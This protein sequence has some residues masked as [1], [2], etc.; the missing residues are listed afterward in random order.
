MKIFDTK[1][2]SYQIIP[3]ETKIE[4]WGAKGKI[5]TDSGVIETQEVWGNTRE[6]AEERAKEKV[7]KLKELIAETKN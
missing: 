4:G 5:Y 2:I 3:I 7:E 1:I 6:E